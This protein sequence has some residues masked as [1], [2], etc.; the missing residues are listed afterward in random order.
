M[1]PHLLVAISSHGFG[2]LAQVAPVINAYEQAAASTAT[3]NFKLTIRSSLPKHQ[4]GWRVNRHFDLDAAS[5]DFGMVMH[6]ALRVD[7]VQSLRQYAAL[8]LQW[9]AQVHQL[10]THLSHLKV[11]AVLA[12]APYLTLAAAHAAKIPSMAICSLNWA[13]ILERCVEQ[14]PQA[15]AEANISG[16]HFAQILQ[17]MRDAYRSAQTILSPE[18]AMES[19]C[20]AAISI[21]PI[22]P[23][24]AVANRAA[25]LRFVKNSVG[26]S[27]PDAEDCWLVLT[28][29][30]GI[31]LPLHPEKW[32]THVL[33]RRVVYLMDP[34]SAGPWE[35]TVATDLTQFEFQSMM[36]SCDLVLTKPGYGMFV[37]TRA[38]GKPMLYLSRAAWPESQCLID[39]AQANSH[40]TE[41]SI[42]QLIS[43][44]FADEL[45]GLLQRPLLKPKQ[46]NGAQ[47]AATHL[48]RLLSAP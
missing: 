35:H 1:T 22:A 20:L 42:N 48:A 29:M 46:F 37:E 4:I 30:G 13:D 31:D 39:W 10:A 15:L 17:Q 40:A 3:P 28:S 14:E 11:S 33:G 38:C 36:A 18:P 27:G 34:A 21:D 26:S 47:M 19:T 6:D 7:L 16:A 23:A 9:E 8:H 5:D 25:L 45:A 32:P 43:G 44:R 24:W 12:D 2:H 41:L